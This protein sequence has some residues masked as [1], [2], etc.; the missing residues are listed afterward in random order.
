[1]KSGSL[2]KY[3][4][5]F[6]FEHENVLFVLA[7]PAYSQQMVFQIDGQGVRDFL[8]DERIKWIAAEPVLL[9]C[10]IGCGHVW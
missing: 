10:P 9:S 3:G 6:V 4:D 2:S 5:S 7:F 8:A 1:L